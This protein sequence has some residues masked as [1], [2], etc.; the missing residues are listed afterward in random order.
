MS[1]SIPLQPVGSPAPGPSL[2]ETPIETEPPSVLSAGESVD[3]DEALGEHESEREV[4]P[5]APADRGRDAW[6][7]L[8]GSTVIETVVWGLL[9]AVGILQHYWTT[10][11]FP[12]HEAT[13]TLAA[14]LMNGLTFMSA[15]I[16]GP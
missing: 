10:E 3:G 13:V 12:E 1:S 11:Q 7:F 14:A 16:F 2:P 5:L 4:R 6:L 15:G 9:N 8:L